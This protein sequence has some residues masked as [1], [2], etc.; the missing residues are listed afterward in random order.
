M[1]QPVED[2]D[3]EIPAAPGRSSKSRTIVRTWDSDDDEGEIVELPRKKKK[4]RKSASREPE[5]HAGFWIRAIPFLID[6]VLSGLMYLAIVFVLLLFT[7]IIYPEFE[8]GGWI[9]HTILWCTSAF[10]ILIYFVFMEASPLQASPGKLMFGLRV[11]NEEEEPASVPALMVREFSKFLPGMLY[12]TF[13][14]DDEF[15]YSYMRDE[16]NLY[17]LLWLALFIP[18][19]IAAFTPR[20]QALY[21]LI[22]GTYVYSYW[23]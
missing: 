3:G 19:L 17:H 14:M 9:H 2:S 21:D 10:C 18:Y 16:F 6:Y 8:L 4:K 15:F 20:K 13:F 12:S 7:H 23:E 5:N 1:P 22:A 11:G